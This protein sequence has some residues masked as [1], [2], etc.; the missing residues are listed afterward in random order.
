MELIEKN[1]NQTTFIVQTKE[2]LANAI[3]RYINEIDILAIDEVEIFKNDSALFDETVA[4]RIGL[5]P[6]KSENSQKKELELK[7]SQNKEGIVYSGELK[8]SAE[9]VYG[10]IP[11]TILNKGQEIEI[12][13]KARLGKGS[14]HAK[15]SPGI[16]FY[17]NVSEITMDKSFLEKIRKVCPD[18]DIKEK[19]NKITIKDNKKK[20]IL[21]V[22]EGIV[23]KEK[24][25]YNIEDSDELIVTIESFGQINVKDIFSKAI[26]E[27]KSDLDEVTKKIDKA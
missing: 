23:E 17:R 26:K 21:E 7:L 14:E 25:E 11:I 13:A 9:V 12:L 19:G 6:L 5:I 4:H 24:K 15:F 2:S 16:L 20:S 8:G 3:R 18:A 10:E 1:Q 27:L 22:C